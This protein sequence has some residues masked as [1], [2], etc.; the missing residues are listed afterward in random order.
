V[1]KFAKRSGV[2]LG[3]AIPLALILILTVF[4]GA[5]LAGWS[6]LPGEVLDG[7][8]VFPEDVSEISAGYDA[9]TWG[10]SNP[11]LR[12]QFAKMS[13]GAFDVAQALPAL[14]TFS[15]VPAT[16]TFY[17]YVEG[18]ATAGLIGGYPDGTFKPGRTITRQEAAA[19]IARRLAQEDE[20]DLARHYDDSQVEAILGRYSDA[21]LVSQSLR[22]EVAYAIERAVLA[23]S[24]GSLRPG[25]PLTRIQ[26]ASMLIR[27]AS[28]V[29]EV[30]EPFTIAAV[31]DTQSYSETNDPAFAAQIN[32]LLANAEAKNIAFVTHLGDVVDDSSDAEQW[33]NAMAAL[34]PLLD[35]DWLP[36]SI[37]RGNHDN[38]GVFLEN[39]PVSSMAAK[40]WFVDA[41]PSGLTQAQRFKVQ[42]KWFVHVGFQMAPSAAELQWANELLARPTLQNLPTIVST[43]DYVTRIGLSSNGRTIWNDFVKKN[44]M[45]FMVLNGHQHVENAV[46][47]YNDAGRP[48]YQML[49]DYQDRDFGGLGLMRL[50]TI[51]PV[52][53][54][55][56]VKTFSPYYQIET[57]EEDANGDPIIEV[58]TNHFETDSDSQFEYDVNIKELL[59]LNPSFGFGPELPASA[60]PKLEA[61]PAVSREVDGLFV[62]DPG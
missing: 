55:I 8:G 45:I 40:P 5:A 31:P 62:G 20:I 17:G 53:N 61:I 16:E 19:I 26:G 44:P 49:S 35:Q 6:D 25:A 12:S 14:P 30:T 54:K 27:A 37:V 29:A 60:L 59:R 22:S 43:H 51:D 1:I 52:A 9:T 36:F 42:G 23:G 47:D 50:V 41:S 56:E 48:V 3:M 11:M 15:D 18:A 10:P 7:Y 24:Q 34:Q 33:E 32:W 2:L 21:G 58:D 57:D 28:A 4:G 39:L 46:V 38:P 13:T